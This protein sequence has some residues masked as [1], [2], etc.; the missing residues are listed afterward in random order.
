LLQIAQHRPTT[1]QALE[2]VAD[3][4]A[5]KMR[6]YGPEILAILQSMK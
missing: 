6:T 5:W 2:Q 1:A 4:G 3:I